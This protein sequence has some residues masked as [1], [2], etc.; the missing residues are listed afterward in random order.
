MSQNICGAEEGNMYIPLPDCQ[1]KLGASEYDRLC[2]LLL[3]SSDYPDECGHLGRALCPRHD[4]MDYLIRGL[5]LFVICRYDANI[6]P[7]QCALIELIPAR[8][9][10]GEKP[11]RLEFPRESLVRNRIDDAHDGD[12][13]GAL[14]VLDEG[15]HRIAGDDDEITAPS[16]HFLDR[17][18]ELRFHF[19]RMTESRL[20]ESREG[21]VVDIHGRKVG[22][23]VR[24][25]LVLCDINDAPAELGA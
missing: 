5:L 6:P 2:A 4:A 3:E 11:H 18:D 9:F 12:V 23:L 22:V 17:F 13:D 7:G 21:Q 14:H 1:R 19:L 16:G 10:R 15:V 20:V 25:V 8:T 24:A